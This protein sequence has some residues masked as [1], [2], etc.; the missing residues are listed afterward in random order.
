MVPACSPEQAPAADLELPLGTPF[1]LHPPQKALSE[2]LRI[3]I[4]QVID[5]RCPLDVNCIWEGEVSVRL[6]AEGA[7]DGAELQLTL[8]QPASDGRNVVEWEGYRITLEAVSMPPGHK[9]N[10]KTEDYDVRLLVDR[11]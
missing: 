3:T 11:L 10:W 4:L 9:A 5:S 1:V 7:Q 6:L 2:A 8:H